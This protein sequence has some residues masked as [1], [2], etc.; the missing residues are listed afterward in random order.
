MPSIEQLIR[1]G[2]RKKVRKSKARA[3]QGNPQM[4]GVVLQ[5]GIRKPKK[6][7]SAERKVARVRL[8]N[9]LEVACFIPGEGHNI[10]EHSRVLVR[11]GRTADLPGYRYKIVRGA[12]DLQGVDRETSKSKYGTGQ[13]L[14]KKR[15]R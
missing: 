11:G 10:Q 1:K 5:T 15:R 7:N 12:A 4:G 2:R 13:R 8:T 9:G 14:K 6:P 3:L